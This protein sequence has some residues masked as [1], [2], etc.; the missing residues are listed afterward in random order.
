MARR[1]TNGRDR[2]DNAAGEEIGEGS[3]KGARDYADRTKAFL[4]TEG[5][6][7]TT[8]A[9]QARKALEGEEGAELEAA[10]AEGREHARS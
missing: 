6:R 8:R 7:V 4:K 5:E 3:Y 10:E 2:A 1:R 9:R